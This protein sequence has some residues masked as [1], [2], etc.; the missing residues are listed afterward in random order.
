MWMWSSHGSCLKVSSLDVQ[1]GNFASKYLLWNFWYTHPKREL[2]NTCM[3]IIFQWKLQYIFCYSNLLYLLCLTALLLLGTKKAVACPKSKNFLCKNGWFKNKPWGFSITFNKVV[4][5][6]HTVNI[7]SPW[8]AISGPTPS[9]YRE[10]VWTCGQ[11]SEAWTCPASLCT[12][13]GTGN[14]LLFKHHII[15]SPDSAPHLGSAQHNT[16]TEGQRWHW[17]CSHSNVLT[18]LLAKL[19]LLPSC[20]PQPFVLTHKHLLCPV[21][22]WLRKVWNDRWAGEVRESDCLPFLVSALAGVS[23]VDQQHKK[24]LCHPWLRG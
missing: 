3:K 5:K 9:S 8:H 13:L 11:F 21:V 24:P 16:A 14:L 10:F 12:G 4:T 20:C 1:Q 2:Q 22:T 15:Y 6:I 17:T 18:A 23:S 19:V 7:I